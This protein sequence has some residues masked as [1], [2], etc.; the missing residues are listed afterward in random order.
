MCF[1]THC[2]IFCISGLQTGKTESLDFS[3]ANKQNINSLILLRSSYIFF[4]WYASTIECY[5][6]HYE[7][8]C[9]LPRCYW[10]SYW[11]NQCLYFHALS[12]F[13][14]P[15]TSSILHQFM[16]LFHYHV[17]VLSFIFPAYKVWETPRLVHFKWGILHV[18]HKWSWTLQQRI[19]RLFSPFMFTFLSF[20]LPSLC[21][22]KTFTFQP[23]YRTSW[24][25][26]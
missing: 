5:P 2:N 20:L 26:G 1:A 16:C 3:S 23:R 15:S 21:S 7:D 8:S 13:P 6:T 17:L 22:L 9:H 12:P 18:V 14:P 19:I 25:S 11:L 4:S 10:L 24:A